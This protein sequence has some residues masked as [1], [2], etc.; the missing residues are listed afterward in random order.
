M[1]ISILLSTYNGALYI[2]EQIDSILAQTMTSWTLYIRDDGSTDKTVT[3]INE[4]CLKFP[5]KI[6]Y[7]KDN[8]G[9]LRSAGSFMQMLSIIESDYYMFCDQD[10]V[11][12]STK[13]EKSYQ[14]IKE[15]EFN[16]PE[17]SALVFTDLFVV[18]FNLKLIDS[19]MWNYSKINPD[20]A[21]NLYMTT[22]LSSVTGC[23][24]MINNLLKNQVLPYPKFARMHD[25]W[26]NLNAVHFGVVDYIN[27]PT[28]QY[29]QHNE[30]VLGA[31]QITKNHYLKKILSLKSVINDN[32]KV[33]KMLNAL[34]FELNYFKVFY[35]KIK[36]ILNI[37][38]QV[39][40]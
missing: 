28:I 6:K 16:N 32:I 29:R 37:N 30:N 35:T 38:L 40:R 4:Y 3:I 7:V 15:L 27:E 17:K 34:H 13:I 2:E 14:K 10:D 23:T 19:S 36:I 24:V 1:K 11:W 25:W 22:C 12:L 26:I 5:K 39:K 33:F 18:D 21:K 31:D 9:N 8:L 20:N